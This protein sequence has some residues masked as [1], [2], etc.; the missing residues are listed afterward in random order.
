[1][2]PPIYLKHNENDA[3]PTDPIFYWVTGSGNFICR[4]T[5]VSKT[6]ARMDRRRLTWETWDSIQQS[7]VEKPSW[8]A[9]KV[10]FL[11][12]APHKPWC[13]VTYPPVPAN[14]IEYTM[15]FFRRCYELYQSEAIVLLLWD[16]NERQYR[17]LIPNQRVN[18]SHCEYDSPTRLT[19]N[20][21]LIIGDIHSHGSMSA[22]ASGTDTHDET[23]RDGLHG[24]I[25]S[26]DKKGKE[27]FHL[28]LCA[29]GERFEL[30]WNVVFDK[31]DEKSIRRIGIPQKKLERVE[32]KKW[33]LG[34][35]WGWYGRNSYDS[36]DSYESKGRRSSNTYDSYDHW[37]KDK[38]GIDS[39]LDDDNDGW[40][41]NA[42]GFWERK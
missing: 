9:E 12:L 18:S 36:Y 7:Y 40:F 6:D 14:I 24:I 15:A 5:G 21:Y 35:N 30:N 32:E 22:F 4:N 25:G 17:L 16:R 27:C 42:D 34:G 20:G 1:M 28:E 39:T 29:D 19:E 8:E 10:R 13:E 26:V 33:N 11:P 38:Y 3:R 41:L 37:W 23:Y 31:H 2:N